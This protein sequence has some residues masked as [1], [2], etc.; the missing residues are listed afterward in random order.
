AREAYQKALEIS[1]RLGLQEGMANQCVNMGSIAKQQGDQAKAREFLT[2][3]RDIFRKIGIPH[4][5]EKVQ[6]LLDGLDG[7]DE[8]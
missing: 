1:K 5:V 4:K 3:A 6:G 7:E 2:K 8:G